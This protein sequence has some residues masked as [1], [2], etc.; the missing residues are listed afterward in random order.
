MIDPAQAFR[1]EVVEK[2]TEI[3]KII[4]KHKD[5]ATVVRIGEYINLVQDYAQ[6]LEAQAGIYKSK[7]DHFHI[8]GNKTYANGELNVRPQIDN[9]QQAISYNEYLHPRENILY[10]VSTRYTINSAQIGCIDA[11]GLK[12]LI[13]GQWLPMEGWEIKRLQELLKSDNR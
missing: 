9:R 8:D 7:H 12:V 11:P 2:S 5:N 10:R 4:G 13:A 6:V 1:K 3:A